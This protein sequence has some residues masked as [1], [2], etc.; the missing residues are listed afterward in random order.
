MKLLTQAILKSLPAL[1]ETEGIDI[2]NK[3]IIKKF[4]C[5]WNHWTWYAVEYDPKTETFFG[6]VQG[7]YDE[8][9]YFSLAEMRKIRGSFG[10]KIERDL[11][12]KPCK[13]KNLKKM[14]KEVPV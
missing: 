11:Y 13:F 1:Y 12:F 4:F 10:L 5:H 6:F 9:G 8:W 2:D 14:Y 7:N 3:K